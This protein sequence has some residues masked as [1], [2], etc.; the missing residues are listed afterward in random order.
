MFNKCFEK[1]SYRFTSSVGQDIHGTHS[2]MDR[3]SLHV[4]PEAEGDFAHTQQF[5]DSLSFSR[6]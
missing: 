6:R 5:R 2:H 3:F 1:D 4:V